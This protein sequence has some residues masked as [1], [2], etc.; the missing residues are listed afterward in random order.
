MIFISVLIAALLSQ[1]LPS[2]NQSL[3]LSRILYLGLN[4]IS[5]N[6]DFLSGRGILWSEAWT[7][8]TINPWSGYGP[9]IMPLQ[10]SDKIYFQNHPHNIFLQCWLNWGVPGLVLSLTS[11]FMLVKTIVNRNHSL[12]N[13]TQPVY[14]GGLTGIS[15]L[16]AD[17]M[18]DGTLFYSQPL[19]FAALFA[20]LMVASRSPKT[21]P[22][23][24]IGSPGHKGWS[25]TARSVFLTAV[26]Y[27]FISI[28]ALTSFYSDRPKE[29]DDIRARIVRV[30][31]IQ[32]VRIGSDLRYVSWLTEWYQGADKVPIDEWKWLA[33]HC[34]GHLCSTLY[35]ALILQSKGD[36][37]SAQ[38]LFEIVSTSHSS[39]HGDFARIQVGISPPPLNR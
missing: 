7:A 14:I 1:A 20:S 31:P 22:T 8:I 17:G 2:F 23:P 15:Y 28:I 24:S 36:Q 21:C 5:E 6:H 10:V 32:V 18:I 12:K 4:G 39:A 9:G 13:H 19:M 29:A 30:F 27:I 33:G 3:G 16:V 25:F 38:E 26:A 11:F 37:Q 35:Q 34:R